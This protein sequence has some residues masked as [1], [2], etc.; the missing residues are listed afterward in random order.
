MKATMD[1]IGANA[2]RAARM[3][4]QAPTRAKN[5]ALMRAAERILKAR[6]KIQAANA[7]DMEAAKAAGLSEAMLDRLLL[8]DARIEAMAEGLR[9]IAELPDPVGAIREMRVRPSGIRVGKMRVPLGVIGVI[10][11]SRPNVSA[12]AAGLCV[13]SG[14]AV[15]LRGGS[16][17]AR[18][19]AAIVDEI[20]AA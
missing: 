5:E 12:D 7:E 10:F 1:A 20:R 17:A 4:A 11:E 14:N 9:Q 8:T 2:R 19:N 15:I 3:L 6:A 18:S 13:K 16:E